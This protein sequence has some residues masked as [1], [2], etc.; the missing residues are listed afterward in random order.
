[1]LCYVMLCYVMLCYVMLCYVLFCY[2]MLCYAMLHVNQPRVTDAGETIIVAKMFSLCLS[3][4]T[5][6]NINVRGLF[7]K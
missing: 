4:K 7:N 5:V 3:H 1:M 2:A 6:L